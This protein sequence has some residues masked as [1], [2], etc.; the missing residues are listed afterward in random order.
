MRG[1]NGMSQ[2]MKNITKL[3]LFCGIFLALLMI[4]S[5]MMKP[6]KWFDDKLIQNRDARYVQVTEQPENT[7]DVLNLGDSLSLCTFNGMDLWREQGF[8]GFNIGADGLRMAESYYSILNACK[9]QNPKV[10]LIESLYLFRYS[11]GDDTQMLLS[12]PIYYRVPFLKYH[13][14]WKSLVEIPGVMIYHKGY[15]IN[16]HIWSYDGPDNY[17]DLE[18]EDKNQRFTFSWLNRM[19]FHRIQKYCE[20]NGIKIIIYSAISPMNYN[21]KRVDAVA[22]FAREENVEYLDLNQHVQE[23]GIDWMRDTN[24][25]GDHINYHGCKKVTAFI[26]QYLKE[27]TDLVDHRGD[28]AYQDWDEE[29]VA[30]D[31][32]VKDMD[33]ISFAD[34]YNQKRKYLKQLK[35]RERESKRR[36]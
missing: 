17:M 36:R 13:N 9:K 21:Q 18:L 28:P 25:A 7:I 31:Q 10:L 4:F 12:Q 34:I 35:Q 5:L 11:L 14:I 22:Q 32:L 8:T 27:N 26:G 6:Q 15:T 1:S 19:W 23:I 20:E 30:F 3:I 16:E 2:K 29:L 24:D 33:G